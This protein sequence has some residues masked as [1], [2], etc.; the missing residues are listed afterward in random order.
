MYRSILCTFHF[1]TA[2]VKKQTIQGNKF[3]YTL[4]LLNEKHVNTYTLIKQRQ[5]LESKQY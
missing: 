1:L 2:Y 3:D 4:C 5:H